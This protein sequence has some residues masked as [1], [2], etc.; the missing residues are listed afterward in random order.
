MAMPQRLHGRR[1]ANAFDLSRVIEIR[2]AT[3]AVWNEEQNAME[4]GSPSH[5][6]DDE[7]PALQ[8]EH[9]QCV[10]CDSSISLRMSQE[11]NDGRVYCILC[12]APRG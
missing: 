2:E 5:R 12:G 6:N 11:R 10:M 7:G 9:S 4:A 1:L 3:E 8:R